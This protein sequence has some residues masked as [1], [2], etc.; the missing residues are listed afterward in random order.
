MLS[1]SSRPIVSTASDVKVS[2]EIPDK[3]CREVGPVRGTTQGTKPDVEKAIEDMKKEAA[4]KGANYVKM[5]T[6][7]SYGTA[8]F[9]TAFECP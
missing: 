3:S 5:E 4:D 8:A 9:G 7:S 1:C 2:R 6:S